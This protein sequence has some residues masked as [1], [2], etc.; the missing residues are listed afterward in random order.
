MKVDARRFLESICTP[1]SK[2]IHGRGGASQ[3]AAVQ[4]S[5]CRR[6]ECNSVLFLSVVPK[7][8]NGTHVSIV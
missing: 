4:E 3:A 7:Q 8:Q 1:E 5:E 2:S 6:R